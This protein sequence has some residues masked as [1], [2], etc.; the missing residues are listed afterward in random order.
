MGELQ[1]HL[2]VRLPSGYRSYL[3]SGPAVAIGAPPARPDL[4]IRTYLAD[5]SG[6]EGDSAASALSTLDAPDAPPDVEIEVAALDVGPTLYVE[7]EGRLVSAVELVSPRNKD[8]PSARAVYASRYAAYLIG[9]V[10]LMLVDP[11]PRPAGFSFADAIAAELGIANQASLPTPMA[12]S[13]RVGEPGATGG[14]LLGMWRK[15]LAPGGPLPTMRLAL[16]VND[17]VA[18]DLETTYSRAAADAYLT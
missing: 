12:I 8:R 16:T 2:K 15:S 17:S 6:V 11:H 5:D 10:H 4:S 9:G 1:R 18:I 7:R 3:G 14:R 13:Y